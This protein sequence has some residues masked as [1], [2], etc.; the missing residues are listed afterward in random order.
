MVTISVGCAVHV[1]YDHSLIGPRDVLSY[2]QVCYCQTILIIIII[3]AIPDMDQKLKSSV[4]KIV[5]YI[6]K[7]IYPCQ[8]CAVFKKLGMLC[9]SKQTFHFTRPCIKI[10]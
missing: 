5:L 2:I 9:S 10:D 4:H 3:P 7:L 6:S 1:E 8:Q